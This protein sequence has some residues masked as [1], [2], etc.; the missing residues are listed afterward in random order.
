MTRECGHG[1]AGRFQTI[2]YM[3]FAHSHVRRHSVLRIQLVSEQTGK[4][5]VSRECR[6]SPNAIQ[7]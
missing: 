1:T 7:E 3:D 6:R 5:A 2:G 4:D